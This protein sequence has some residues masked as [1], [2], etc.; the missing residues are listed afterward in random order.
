MKMLNIHKCRESR[1]KKN[2]ND[3]RNVEGPH[4]FYMCVTLSRIQYTLAK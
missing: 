4:E 3:V 2:S 1:G